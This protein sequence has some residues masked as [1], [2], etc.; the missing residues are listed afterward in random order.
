MQ[1]VHGVTFAHLLVGRALTVGR[2]ERFLAAL[3][4]IHSSNGIVEDHISVPPS[5]ASRLNALGESPNRDVDIYANYAAKVSERYKAFLP[6]YQDLGDDHEAISS[7]LLAFLQDFE[8]D[9]RAQAAHVIHGQCQFDLSRKRRTDRT[10]LAGDPVFS[11]ALF[12]KDNTVV[13]IDVRGRQGDVLT[14]RG[15]ALYDLAKVY[16]SCVHSREPLPIL[17]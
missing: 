6:V 4:R 9:D 17:R 11:N 7:R 12:T 15:D 1:R 8:A 5:L 14:L 10:R 13:F 2:L 16:Q 3:S